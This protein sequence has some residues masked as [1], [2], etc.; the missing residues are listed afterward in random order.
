M[1][2]RKTWDEWVQYLRKLSTRIHESEIALVVGLM[3]LEQAKDIWIDRGVQLFDELIEST[4]HLGLGISPDRYHAIR[5]AIQTFGV[6]NVKRW[7]VAAARYGCRIPDA[8]KRSDY[9]KKVRAWVREYDR[10][11][12]QQVA[13]RLYREVVPPPPPEPAQDVV[14]KLRQDLAGAEEE[15]DNRKL[16]IEVLICMLEDVKQFLRDH[17]IRYDWAKAQLKAQAEVKRRRAAE[18]SSK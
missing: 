4:Q 15:I 7:G 6:A 17:N 1:I 18:N 10:I 16:R 13:W 14:G 5:D 11:L 2:E 12:S 9:L 8:G 3:E